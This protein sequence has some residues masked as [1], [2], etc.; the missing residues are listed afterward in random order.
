MKYML[1]YLFMFSQQVFSQSAISNPTVGSQSNKDHI[2]ITKVVH[3]PSS[4]TFHLRIV[5][6]TKNT[7]SCRVY[8]PG[9]ESA[10]YLTDLS[11]KN[12]YPLRSISGSIE[13]YP[14]ITNV[15][16]GKT[17]NFSLRFDPIP[18][19]IKE[20]H[21]IEGKGNYKDETAWNFFNVEVRK[22][23]IIENN[24][25]EELSYKFAE[26]LGNDISYLEENLIVRAIL[27]ENL[28]LNRGY[29]VVDA[30]ARHL[31]EG[32]SFKYDRKLYDKNN[33]V[34]VALG[35]TGVLDLDVY[36]YDSFG[37]RFNV[38]DKDSKYFSEGVGDEGMAI[39]S[40]RPIKLQEFTIRVDNYDSLLKDKEYDALLM[41]AYK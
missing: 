34:I 7:F 20:V 16:P 13:I 11:Y 14:N 36:I 30:T 29:K 3:S 2:S 26:F 24:D 12:K 35:E 33:Y 23:N 41:I 15:E 38:T 18:I 10:F 1:I 31:K 21:L 39:L 22:K 40:C 4:T 5:N 32:E 17:I 19:S 8:M 6:N 37:K 25:S 9:S 27:V 28:L